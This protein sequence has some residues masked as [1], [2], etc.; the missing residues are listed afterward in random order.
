[1]PDILSIIKKHP[2]ATLGTIAGTGI[3]G[4]GLLSNPIYRMVKTPATIVNELQKKELMRQQIEELK[5]IRN[6]LSAQAG[7][8]RVEKQEL[9]INPLS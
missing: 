8:S 2:K 3:I 7:K 6:S 4:L 5:G 1:M 9:I